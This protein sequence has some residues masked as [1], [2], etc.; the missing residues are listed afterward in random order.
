MLLL[1]QLQEV[2]AVRV[3]RLDNRDGADKDAAGEVDAAGLGI[4]KLRRLLHG[5]LIPIILRR[6]TTFLWSTASPNPRSL[7]N[8]LPIRH[9][10]WSINT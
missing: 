3:A 2:R 1:Q 4:L 10:P 8:G 9:W 6:S 7:P 5:L